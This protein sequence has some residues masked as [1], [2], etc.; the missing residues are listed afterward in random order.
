MWLSLPA[1]GQREQAMDRAVAQGNLNKIERLIKQQVR[2]HRK[3]VV[4][5][6]PYDST[7]T[8]KSLVPALDSITAWL[9]RQESIEAA[10][11]DKCQMKI[12]I[13]PGHSSIGIR[14]QGESEMIEKCFYVQEGTIGKLHFFG[15]R[16]QLFRT[17]L[18]LKYEKMY[19][20]PGFIELQQQN[21]ADRD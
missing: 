16:P 19:D 10:Y 18:V 13:Y 20:C 14:I 4:L 21:C 7:V 9:D 11:W 3:A 12:D 8:Y 17:R 5:T 15:W 1:F 2:K 6:N